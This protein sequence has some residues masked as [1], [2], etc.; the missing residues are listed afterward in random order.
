MTG[1]GPLD[2]GL[3][4]VTGASSSTTCRHRLSDGIAKRTNLFKLYVLAM[5][6]SC[7]KISHQF[8]NFTPHSHLSFH[9]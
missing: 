4:L 5:A 6:L 2:E 7:R 3:F 8:S 9:A 1:Q